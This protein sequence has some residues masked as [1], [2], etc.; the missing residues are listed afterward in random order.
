MSRWPH[1]P[2][3]R[4]DGSALGRSLAAAVG[5]CMVVGVGGYA[6]LRPVQHGA[7]ALQSVYDRT[8]VPP[9]PHLP[10]TTYVYDRHGHLLAV[11]HGGVNRTPVPLDRIPKDLRH[12]VIAAEDAHF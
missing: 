12:A 2:F 3:R 11:L 10:Q 9:M 7:V 8:R 1:S 5:L 6:L 4:R